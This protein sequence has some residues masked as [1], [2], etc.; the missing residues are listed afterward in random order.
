MAGRNASGQPRQTS[1][2][3]P[4]LESVRPPPAASPALQAHRAPQV[5][6]KYPPGNTR[7]L[8]AR[9]FD[10]P[11]MILSRKSIKHYLEQSVTLQKW[12]QQRTEGKAKLWLDKKYLEK[13][14]N[15]KVHE[16]KAAEIRDPGVKARAQDKIRHL[17]QEV[18]VEK[19]KILTKESQHIKETERAWATFVSIKAHEE[20]AAIR[21]NIRNILGLP[22]NPLVTS[23]VEKLLGSDGTV[24]QTPSL[25]THTLSFF[26]GSPLTHTRMSWEEAMAGSM[27]GIADKS[28]LNNDIPYDIKI[29]EWFAVL[30]AQRQVR[31]TGNTPRDRWVYLCNMLFNL[32]ASIRILRYQ[33]EHK[34][35][36]A[37]TKCVTNPPIPGPM[38][39][40]E[41]MN[42]VQ[43]CINQA[44]AK[45]RAADKEVVKTRTAKSRAAKNEDEGLHMMKMRQEVQQLEMKQRNAL[46]DLAN[47]PVG[48]V[49]TTARMQANPYRSTGPSTSSSSSAAP[50][51]A[52]RQDFQARGLM[53][54]TGLQRRGSQDSTDDEDRVRL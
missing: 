44:M 14:D 29:P 37:W 25:P 4:R 53:V 46:H 11:I 47:R 45:V 6:D 24:P 9:T 31:L 7:P 16:R 43:A 17:Q 38:S 3:P 42:E 54:P 48:S 5:F 23:R 30:D 20:E 28:D 32:E 39:S 51:P 26:R 49:S 10:A 36:L 13:V 1:S 33:E 8:P 19:Q 52:T 18:S 15:L 27:E 2:A 12:A 21:H 40:Q 41:M 50:A 34:D 35:E 22:S